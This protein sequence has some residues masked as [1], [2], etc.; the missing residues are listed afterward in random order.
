MSDQSTQQPQQATVVVTVD[1]L[2]SLRRRLRALDEES[3]LI[4]QTICGM[5]PKIVGVND[6]KKTGSLDIRPPISIK[7][8]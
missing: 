7:K 3:R 6:K 5:L 2:H 1:A 8:N 4:Q